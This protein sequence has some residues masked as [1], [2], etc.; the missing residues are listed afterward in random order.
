MFIM[1][2]NQQR[3]RSI[4]FQTIAAFR[5]REEKKEIRSVIRAVTCTLLQCKRTDRDRWF[6]A[7]DRSC[8]LNRR[9]FR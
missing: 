4:A 1:V 8:A 7:D 5:K 9:A 2:R 3:A 6:Y